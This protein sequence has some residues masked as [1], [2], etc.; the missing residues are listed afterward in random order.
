MPLE[1]IWKTK[2][3]Y[4]KMSS[5]PT[6][7]P[8]SRTAN[9]LKAVLIM[10]EKEFA[11]A[12]AEVLQVDLKRRLFVVAFAFSPLRIKAALAQLP[13]LVFLHTELDPNA[14]LEFASVIRQLVPVAKIIGISPSYDPQMEDILRRA[15]A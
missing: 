6:E 12:L 13:D 1:Q 5:Y 3:T 14:V 2:F 8:S 11:L 10:P 7:D 9:S 15:G 4:R